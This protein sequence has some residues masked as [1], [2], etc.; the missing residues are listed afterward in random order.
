MICTYV[1]FDKARVHPRIG[2]VVPYKDIL[3]GDI[4]RYGKN[5][6]LGSDKWARIGDILHWWNEKSQEWDAYRQHKWPHGS[7]SLHTII[8]RF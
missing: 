5:P 4:F 6:I 7:L 8:G 1:Q 2:L 3:E